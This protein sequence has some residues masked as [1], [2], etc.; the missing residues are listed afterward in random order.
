MDVK[1]YLQNLM[2]IN[3]EIIKKIQN[4]PE[5]VKTLETI[6]NHY[7]HEESPPEKSPARE[8][9]H[10]SS[11]YLAASA[12]NIWFTTVLNRDII[13][14][15]EFGQ[16]IDE[17]QGS[18]YYF[19]EKAKELAIIAGFDSNEIRLAFT[20]GIQN[21]IEHGHDQN[22]YIEIA[23]ENIN[24]ADLYFEMSFKHYMPTMKFYSLKDADKNADAGMQDLINPRGRGEYLMREVMNERKFFNGI[25]KRK[26]G[27]Q[28]FFFK[29]LM[30]KYK[31][32]KPK[33]SLHRLT[34]EFKKYIDSL[35]DFN[36]ALFVRMNYVDNTKELVLSEKNAMLDHTK[37]I[38]KKHNYQFKGQEKYRNTNFSFWETNIADDDSGY[39][40]DRIIVELET[41]IIENRE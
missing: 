10:L 29:R 33:P 2:K 8:E 19:K 26:D 27:S 15:N 20:E 31:N 3:N 21:I 5:L 36:T 4:D 34:D 17:T 25:E 24:S 41:I 39:S 35:S 12:N 7:Q 40:F 1:N 14:K 32:P 37:E 18:M 13:V 22:V 16:K 30:R 38:M 23:I 9:S 6:I 28:V 11:P